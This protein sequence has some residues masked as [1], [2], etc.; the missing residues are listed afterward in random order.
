MHIVC[1]PVVSPQIIPCHIPPST[2]DLYTPTHQAHHQSVLRLRR[3][4]C[5]LNAS[6]SS[7]SMG[8]V[9]G[10][11]SVAPARTCVS[12]MWVLEGRAHQRHTHT[13]T[14]IKE[15]T[16]SDGKM[17]PAPFV[18]LLGV[19]Y[20]HLC[21]ELAP[22]H[23]HSLSSPPSL[24]PPSP[25]SPSSHLCAVAQCESAFIKLNASGGQVHTSANVIV[26]PVGGWVGG[27]GRVVS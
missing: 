9:R 3:C 18:A 11:R 16:S 15:L 8:R 7:L 23:I 19:L 12:V 22:F 4:T 27:C 26:Q 5:S 17:A 1:Q 25:Q 13:A 10:K 14:N 6:G 24:P 2:H 21:Q 20:A